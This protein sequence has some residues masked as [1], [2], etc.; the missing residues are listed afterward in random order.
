MADTIGAATQR[1]TGAATQRAIA[2]VSAAVVGFSL[3]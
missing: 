2:R 3:Y 1:A